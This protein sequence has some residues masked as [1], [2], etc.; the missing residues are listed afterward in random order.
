MTYLSDQMRTQLE[1]PRELFHSRAKLT[2]LTVFM[3]VVA[4][5]PLYVVSAVLPTTQIREE[6]PL[7]DAILYSVSAITVLLFFIRIVP[8][9]AS[10]GRPVIT[11]SLGGLNVSGKPVMR[12]DDIVMN[13]WRTHRVMWIKTG[14]KLIIHT[15]D[16]KV[17]CEVITLNCS[18]DEYLRL[19][20]LY[21]RAAGGTQAMNSER[22]RS[23]WT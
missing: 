6:M 17:V 5:V 13:E 1:S 22:H 14:A 11:V 16:R 20:Q 8:K 19:C 18:A 7:V 15:H 9:W 2:V 12:W 4:I 10:N 21:E 23:V 3:G